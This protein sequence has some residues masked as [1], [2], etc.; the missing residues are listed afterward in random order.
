MTSSLREPE[1]NREGALEPRENL[2][3]LKLHGHFCTEGGG[4]NLIPLSVAELKRFLC[5]LKPTNKN[6]EFFYG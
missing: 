1:R 4:V 6:K 5:F 2:A 3:K